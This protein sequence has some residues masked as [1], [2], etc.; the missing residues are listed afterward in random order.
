MR[1]PS[2]TDVSLAYLATEKGRPISRR[3]PVGPVLKTYN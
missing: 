3:T 2:Q 1:Y